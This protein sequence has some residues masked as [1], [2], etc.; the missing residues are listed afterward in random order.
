MTMVP[1]PPTTPTSEGGD[2]CQICG[3]KTISHNREQL[4]RCTNKAISQEI[5]KDMKDPI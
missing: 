1:P 3:K 4:N 2:I 5:L